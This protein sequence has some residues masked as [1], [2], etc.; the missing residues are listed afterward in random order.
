MLLP[1]TIV[2]HLASACSTGA[3]SLAL[4]SPTAPKSS[5]VT[6]TSVA[7][8]DTNA[9]VVSAPAAAHRGSTSAI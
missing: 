8:A 5:G 4:P 2:E 3:Q 7:E 1:Y 9:P 6:T